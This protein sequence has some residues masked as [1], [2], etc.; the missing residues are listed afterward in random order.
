M[1]KENTKENQKEEI[2][3]TEN[4]GDIGSIRSRKIAFLYPG[5][6]SQK[7]GMGLDFYENSPEARKVY[8]QAEEALGIPIRDIC[9]TE[10]EQIHLTE[11]TQPALVTTCLAM[12][13]ALEQQGILPDLTA[14]LSLGEYA[15]VAAAGG[16]A[17]TDAICLVRKRGLL[18]QNTIPAGEGAMSAV[19]G[20]E[21]GKIEEILEQIPD[22]TIANYNCPG[23]IVITGRTEEV[24]KAGERLNEAGARR[25]LPLKVSGPF[26]SPLL[27]PA[28]EELAKEMKHVKFREL[29]VPYVANAVAEMETDA[30]K[31]P[32]LFVTGVSSPVKWQQSME[33]MVK[34]GVD[35]FLE[36]GP[37]KTLSG[38]LKKIA[39][40]AKV[41]SLST[42]TDLEQLQEKI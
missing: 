25:V 39:P 11:Y 28:G 21:A 14:G 34:E 4:T 29:K 6:G 16:L 13:R 35:L 3:V 12:T 10:N 32:E 38:F 2:K 40:E 20:M 18:M 23:Q 7:C 17:D 31:I 33:L 8:D 36:I 1:M 27:I 5:Q 30:R 41:L 24:K 26:H 22:V 42:W 37:G 9:F 19:L 15:A